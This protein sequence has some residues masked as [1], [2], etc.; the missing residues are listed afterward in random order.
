MW[1]VHFVPVAARV[2]FVVSLSP[3]KI[4]HMQFAE[5][6]QKTSWESYL[7]RIYQQ[8]SNVY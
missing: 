3:R 2:N 8:L 6:D 1:S 4:E 5:D 7:N